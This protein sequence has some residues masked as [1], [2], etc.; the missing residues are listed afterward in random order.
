VARLMV[1][2]LFPLTFILGHRYPHFQLK[3]LGDG[4]CPLYLS[5]LATRTMPIGMSPVF[6]ALG[7]AALSIAKSRVRHCVRMSQGP[8]R[9]HP[10]NSQTSNEM[11]LKTPLADYANAARRCVPPRGRMH[12][13]C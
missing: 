11:F 13:A 2:N 7:Y 5:L 4:T 12:K 8:S 1:G 10:R 3:E 6:C 9:T